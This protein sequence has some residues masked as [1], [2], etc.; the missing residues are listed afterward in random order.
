LIGKNLE[1]TQEHF[2]DF[3]V[4]SPMRLNSPK[5]GRFLGV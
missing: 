5:I 2:K 4:A 1:L 3:W